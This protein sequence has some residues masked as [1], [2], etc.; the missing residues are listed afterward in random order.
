MSIKS[1]SIIA[2]ALMT[3]SATALALNGQ[4]GGN[5]SA[6]AAHAAQGGAP[7]AATAGPSAG[8]VASGE[9]SGSGTLGRISS[10]DDQIAVLKRQLQIEKLHA[11]IAKERA[12]ASKAAGGGAGPGGESP[13]QALKAFMQKHGKGKS[14]SSTIVFPNAGN[15]PKSGNSHQGN[16]SPQPGQVSQPPGGPG[17]TST[18]MGTVLEITGMGSHLSA[19][20]SMH[21]GDVWVSRGDSLMDGKVASVDGQGVTLRTHGKTRRLPLS[22]KV[23]ENPDNMRRGMSGGGGGMVP[24]SPLISQSMPHPPKV[25]SGPKGH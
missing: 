11:K 9:A 5:G 18:P 25:S 15:N 21:G 13:S 12:K 22:A 10:L 7:P 24:T 23:F 4:S 3:F 1:K 20:V 19:L 8:A 16:R 2:F 14:G 17:S 6:Q